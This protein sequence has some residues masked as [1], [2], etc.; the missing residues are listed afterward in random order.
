M[1]GIGAAGGGGKST[2]A[3]G[4]DEPGVPARTGGTEPVV[5][6]AGAAACIGAAGLAVTEAGSGSDRGRNGQSH[7]SSVEILVTPTK[8]SVQATTQAVAELV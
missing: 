5:T 3:G 6:K 4:G 8:A 7:Y 2:A 1:E